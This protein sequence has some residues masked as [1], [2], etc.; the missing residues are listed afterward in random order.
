MV[1]L[2][3]KQFDVTNV[4]N[5]I[6][7]CRLTHNRLEVNHVLN[8]RI[9]I[10]LLARVFTDDFFRHFLGQD[11]LASWQETEHLSHQK[12]LIVYDADDIKL[13]YAFSFASL[14][15]SFQLKIVAIASA[16]NINLWRDWI[17]RERIPLL[18]IIHHSFNKSRFWRFQLQPILFSVFRWK[19]K[20]I[21]H[22]EIDGIWRGVPSD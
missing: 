4:T 16:H 12:T 22:H 5:L 14:L 2:L 21:W 10:W 1:V 19:F 3:I 7:S 17:L 13:I 8:T 9:L 11:L 20:Q 6:W 15:F 18:E